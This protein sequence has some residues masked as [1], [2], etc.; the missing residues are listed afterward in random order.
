MK[1]IIFVLMLLVSIT[2]TSCNAPT[3]VKTISA[4]GIE[5]SAEFEDFFNCEIL[6]YAD[7]V[8]TSI[9]IAIDK[10]T[11]VLYVWKCSGYQFGISPIYDSDGS[12]L[13]K[14]K[15]LAKQTKK[16]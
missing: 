11:D 5:S 13:T 12:V 16:D 8:D 4:S 6:V 7:N 2:F 14:E 1:K 9:A 3:E 10:N 15:W